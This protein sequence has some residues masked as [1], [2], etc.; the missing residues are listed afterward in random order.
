MVMSWELARRADV[1]DKIGTGRG[2]PTTNH[3]GPSHFFAMATARTLLQ[4]RA[5]KEE[6]NETLMNVDWGSLPTPQ[7]DGDAGHL[8][9]FR[10]PRT[11]L[12]S[13]NGESVTL[14]EVPGKSVVYIYPRTGKPG[15][16]NPEAW[17]MIPGIVEFTSH[18]AQHPSRC[19]RLH[20]SI[21]RISR[22]RQ[23]TV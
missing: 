16:P 8:R 7:D 2:P 5:L 4:I 3:L 18:H 17:D 11:S 20:T 1:W 10:I 6:T 22:P 12:P 15:E 19:P 9:N 14:A 23:R 13:T 21:V